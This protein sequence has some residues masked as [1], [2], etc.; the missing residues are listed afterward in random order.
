MPSPFPGMDPHIESWIWEDFHARWSPPFTI[1]WL[2]N[3]RMNTMHRSS[4]LFGG[5]KNQARSGC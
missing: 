1:N 4:F 5:S 3:F 2:P